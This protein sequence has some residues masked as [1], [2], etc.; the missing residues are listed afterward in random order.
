LGATPVFVDAQL[1]TFVPSVEDVVAK[2][3]DKTKLIMLPNLIGSKPD[4]KKLREEVDKINPKIILFED[5]CDTMTHT[6]E[7]NIAACSFYASHIMT[8]GNE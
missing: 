2:I 6:K 3:T 4:W 7:T 1:R 5:S 8:C